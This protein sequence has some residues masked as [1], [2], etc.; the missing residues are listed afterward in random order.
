MLTHF[1]MQGPDGRTE[2]VEQ[3]QVRPGVAHS[4]ALTESLHLSFGMNKSGLSLLDVGWCMAASQ[5]TQKC[6]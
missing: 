3:S 6:L 5:D 2:K 1:V 4:I